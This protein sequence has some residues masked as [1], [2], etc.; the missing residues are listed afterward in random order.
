VPD[1]YYPTGPF[2]RRLARDDESEVAREDFLLDCRTE[3]TARAF[4]S[5]LE[6]YREW[7]GRES[8]NPLGPTSEACEAY[9]RDLT[10]GGYSLSTVT[11]RMATLRRFLAHVLDRT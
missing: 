1:D 2:I 5:D 3:G 11:R 4:K 9:R 8:V 7:C 6:D 10:K